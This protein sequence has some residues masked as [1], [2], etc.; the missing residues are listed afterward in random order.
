[1]Y[2]KLFVGIPDYVRI[3]IFSCVRKLSTFANFNNHEDIQ[4]LVQELLLFYIEHFHQREIPSD[5]YVVA[6][7]QN[8]AKKLLKTKMREPF[9][10][11]VYD[12]RG[13]PRRRLCDPF[14][15]PRQ[16]QS[17]L[18]RFLGGTSRRRL[19]RVR[20]LCRQQSGRCVALRPVF[21][22]LLHRSALH[23]RA[24]YASAEPFAQEPHDRRQRRRAAYL[25]RLP[26]RG[27]GQLRQ[28]RGG[29]KSSVGGQEAQIVRDAPR[30][31]GGAHRA[32]RGSGRTERRNAGQCGGFARD[33]R[34]GI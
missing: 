28:D 10:L 20:R 15:F 3:T 16:A 21:H 26:G 23:D 27:L 1:M 4:D 33:R 7:L 13:S 31:F 25:Q 17:D 5:V 12:R 32:R 34:A 29:G 8:Y 11:F 18:R 14:A 9:G 2:D 19:R 22:R 6:S 30:I 24:G